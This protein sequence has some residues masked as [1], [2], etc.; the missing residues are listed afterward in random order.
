M[1]SMR[2]WWCECLTCHWA[3]HCAQE[4]GSAAGVFL[5]YFMAEVC[6]GTMSV[7][8][9]VREKNCNA[10]SLKRGCKHLCWLATCSACCAD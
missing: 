10:V 6:I 7:S 2:P 3:T 8:V 9:R 5:A 1:S 4:D